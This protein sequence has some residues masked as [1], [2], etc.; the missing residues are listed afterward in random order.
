MCNST[1]NFIIGHRRPCVSSSLLILFRVKLIWHVVQAI[2]SMSAFFRPTFSFFLLSLLI[3]FALKLLDS[4]GSVTYFLIK[5]FIQNHFFRFCLVHAL[6][7][8]PIQWNFKQE[9]GVHSIIQ[10]ELNRIIELKK[11]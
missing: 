7:S 8:C 10:N 9:Y 4:F 11:L 5:Y 1:I 2:P 3:H 6:H